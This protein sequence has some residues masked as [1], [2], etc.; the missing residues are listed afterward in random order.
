MEPALKSAVR[1]VHRP[2]RLRTAARHRWDGHKC[3][4]CGLIREGT[5]GR[6]SGQRKFITADG[7]IMAVA[8]DCPGNP[9]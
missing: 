7:E 5:A 1:Q 6:F 9:R 8:G 3:R 4:Q 2:K